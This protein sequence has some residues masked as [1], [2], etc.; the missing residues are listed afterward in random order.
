MNVRRRVAWAATGLV[1]V[2]GSAQAGWEAAVQ[3]ALQGASGQSQP[4]KG[5]HPGKQG[6]GGLAG[7]SSGEMTGGLKEA[8]GNGVESSIKTLGRSNG[9]LGN[10]LV[11]IAMP[12]SLQMV[13]GTA[14]KLGQGR[15]ADEFIASMN[16]AA[17]QAVPEAAAI[18][19]DAI[20]AMT[21][22]DAA[23]IIQGPDDA[24]TRYFRRTSEGALVE[25]FLPI[26]RRATD[27][28]GVTSAYK[29]MVGSAGG[30]LGALGGLTGGSGSLDLDRYVTQ[31]ALDGLFTYIAMEEK[32]IRQNPVARTSDLLRKVFGG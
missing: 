24:A 9:F 21:V 26:V 6:Q 12:E 28:T 31:K 8:L 11:R 5:K 29:G 3:D 4:Q 16:H 2:L 10:Q 18:L 30:A 32:R 25:R 20:R 14:R 15:Y 1:L 22:Q 23:N 17:E 19:G 7:L 27:K 13:E